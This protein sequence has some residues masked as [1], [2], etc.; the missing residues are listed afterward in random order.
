[1][2]SEVLAEVGNPQGVTK[3]T[4]T[5]MRKVYQTLRNIQRSSR[6]NGRKE[7]TKSK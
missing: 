5:Q 7:L 4:E 3:L 1:M 2:Q 6:R